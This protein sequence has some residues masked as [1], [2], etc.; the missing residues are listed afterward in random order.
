LGGDIKR[1]INKAEKKYNIEIKRNIP[2]ELFMRVN[3]LTY[4]RQKIKPFHPEMLQ[5]VITNVRSRNQGDIWGAFDEEGRLHAAVFIA[6]QESCAYY[7]AGG[8][9]PALRDSGAHAFVL[10]QAIC[11]VST[12]SLSFDFEGSM[13]QGVEHFFREFGAKQVPFFT[14]SKG[15][16]SFVKKLILKIKQL[17]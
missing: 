3:N 8:G 2:L 16:M 12:N 1:N 6:W 11:D 14:I 7:I 9:D 10:W 17:R 5:K 15:K 13:I 4:E